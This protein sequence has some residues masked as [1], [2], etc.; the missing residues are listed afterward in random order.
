MTC[1]SADTADDVRCVVALLGT[2]VLAMAHVAT[3]LAD[4]VL[5]V[6]KGTIQ[7]GQL[8]QLVALVVVFTFRCGSGL[9]VVGQLL[10]LHIQLAENHSPSR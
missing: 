3:V 9:F 5:I 2:V 10:S 6:T 8:S 4:L 7:R 1:A